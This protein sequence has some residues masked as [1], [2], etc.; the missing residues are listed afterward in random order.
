MINSLVLHVDDNFFLISKRNLSKAA[1][2][3]FNKKTLD[4]LK[5][6]FNLPLRNGTHI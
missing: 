5:N 3:I 6:R 1:A 4:C 2:G